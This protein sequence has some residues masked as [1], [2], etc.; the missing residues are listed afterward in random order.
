MKNKIDKLIYNLILILIYLLLFPIYSKATYLFPNDPKLG[1]TNQTYQIDINNSGPKLKNNSGVMEIRNSAD[2]AYS[3]LKALSFI[4]DKT[5]GTAGQNCV[6][7]SYLTDTYG[8]CVEGND[9]NLSAN[10]LLKYPTGNPTTSILVYATP[11]SNRSQGSWYNIV[12]TVG[13]PGLDT[14]IAT[15]KAVRDGLNS[16]SPSGYLKADGTIPLTDNW[17]VGNYSITASL[18]QTPQ[19][20]SVPDQITLR[21]KGT[22]GFGYIIKGSTQ[23]EPAQSITLELPST[24]SEPSVGSMIVVSSFSSHSGVFSWLADVAAG[25]PLLSG[26]TTT[27][28]AYA[29]YT[30]SGTSGKT[31]T[32]PSDTATLCGTD[33][34]CS[35]YQSTITFGTGVLSA[36]SINIGTTGSLIIN[37]GGLGS[38]ANLIPKTYSTG[39]GT[40]QTSGISIDSSNNIS[41]ATSYSTPQQASTGGTPDSLRWRGYGTNERGLVFQVDNTVA[42][43]VNT[44]ILNLPL[45]ETN[46]ATGSILYVSSF[47]SH[48]GAFSW[49]ADVAVGQPFLSGG[50]GAAPS[51]AGWYLSGTAGQTYTFPSA[52]QTLASLAGAETFTLKTLTAPLETIGAGGSAGT[53]STSWTPNFTV[54]DSFTLILSGA[55]TINNPTIVAGRFFSVKMTQS[56]TVAP[57]FDTAFKWSGG[58]TPTWSTSATKYDL[59][60]CVSYDGTTFSCNALID[61]R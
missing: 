17:N 35:G 59:V 45:T 22:G 2:S 27:I 60:A 5:S 8:I 37:N 47:A 38:S 49:L 46:L 20:A 54:A 1:T 21:N 13:N 14:N 44:I 61:V 18:F 25:Q 12:T 16:V 41:G 3:T 10:L 15:E 43:P 55:C 9:D 29:G 6:Y 31:Y 4:T 51:Y 39:G 53:C 26:G 32:F 50:I 52:T 33:A 42:E 24:A 19:S 58:T 11:S 23:T 28:P 30:F 48:S 40:L 56:S 36:L 57:T 7:T 34:V